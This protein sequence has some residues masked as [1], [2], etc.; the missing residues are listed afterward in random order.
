MS[1]QM[2]SGWGVRTLASSMGAF[3]P[4]SYHNGSVWPHDNAIAVAGLMRYG[5]V[6]QAQRITRAVLDAAATFGWRM[7]ELW[8]GFSR[9]DFSAPL[10]Y[11]TACSPQAWAAATPIFLLR[12]LLGLNPWLPGGQVRV[13]P[14]VPGEFLPLTVERL[15]LGAGNVRVDVHGTGRD[16]WSIDGLP[17][18]VEVAAAFAR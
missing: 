11:P 18:G 1:P 8:C 6:D 2:F 10:P 14:Q 15:S 7:P 4:L 13:A 12:S 5:F 17:E 3:N 16:D 9:S